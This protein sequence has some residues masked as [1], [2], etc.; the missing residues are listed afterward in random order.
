MIVVEIGSST[1]RLARP[2]APP[3]AP[4]TIAN[5]RWRS[6]VSATRFPLR[7]ASATFIAP[8]SALRAAIALTCW[9][10][11]G[12]TRP[13][14]PIWRPAR[15]ASFLAKLVFSNAA[16]AASSAALSGLFMQFV[17]TGRG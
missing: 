16:T 12:M 4:E 11:A 13:A 10:F 17:G 7:L 9:S 8:N 1:G 2:S 14:K 15:C 3:S 5:W 6:R